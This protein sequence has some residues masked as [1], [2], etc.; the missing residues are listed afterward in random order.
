MYNICVF[1]KKNFQLD[2]VAERKSYCAFRE[3]SKVNLKRNTRQKNESYGIR[4]S[5]FYLTY[6]DGKKNPYFRT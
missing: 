1:N 6:E 3:D 2:E 5:K 4:L